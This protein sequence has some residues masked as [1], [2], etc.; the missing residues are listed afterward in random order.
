MTR[1]SVSLRI[2]GEDDLPNLEH[3]LR[4]LNG[5]AYRVLR[6]GT[7]GKGKL[8]QPCDN[9]VLELAR[10]NDPGAGAAIAVPLATRDK[11]WAAVTETLTKLAPGLAELDRSV[12]T[13]ELYISTIREEDQGGFGIPTELVA[14]AA[15]ARLSIGVSILVMLEWDDSA[16]QQ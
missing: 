14:A 5:M 4:V 15:A 12:C 6:R 7:V 10:W 11:P 9:V 8:V 3:V 16:P 1:F 13:A 2:R